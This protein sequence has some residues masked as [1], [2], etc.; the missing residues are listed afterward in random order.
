MNFN[1][2]LIKLIVFIIIILIGLVISKVISNL[3]RKFAKEL[4]L[5]MVLKKADIKFDSKNFLPSLFR[6]LILILTVMIA[7][8]SVGIT[9]IVI[10]IVFIALVIILI[11]YTLIS[12]KELIPNIYHGIRIKNKYKVG[13]KLKYKSIEGKII[14]MNLAEL[15]VKTKKEV[16]YIPYKLIR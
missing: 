14:K 10:K 4:E 5:T 12:I 2:I 6:Y 13:S 7:L 16:I 15:Q 3:V 11:A 9:K 8:N 1:D